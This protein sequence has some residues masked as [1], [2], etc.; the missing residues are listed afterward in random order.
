MNDRDFQVHSPLLK[1]LHRLTAMIDLL[2][3]GVKQQHSL[4]HTV[5]STVILP[6]L[7]GC[8][9]QLK[10]FLQLCCRALWRPKAR[11]MT[12]AVVSILLFKWASALDFNF[13]SLHCF[14]WYCL[15]K[16][17]GD[18]FC[19]AHFGIQGECETVPGPTSGC[20]KVVEFCH[21]FDRKY[22]WRTWIKSLV[23]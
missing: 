2:C 16:A 12:S 10:D 3:R 5:F 8:L 18:L 17:A 21:P 23:F 20:H 15:T 4:K 11:T 1:L 7:H 6:A 13:A 22:A 19:I 14:D 9:H